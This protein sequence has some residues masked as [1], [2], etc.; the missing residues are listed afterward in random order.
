MRRNN[1]FE[2]FLHTELTHTVHM[3]FFT[4]STSSKKLSL[5]GDYCNVS[6]VSG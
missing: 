4:L 6:N 5:S 1:Q 2:E 3:L